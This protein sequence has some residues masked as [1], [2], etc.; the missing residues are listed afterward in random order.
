MW[1]DYMHF[2]DHLIFLEVGYGAFSLEEYLIVLSF[3]HL[4]G[5]TL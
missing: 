5:N 2:V 1:I 4:G 3:M